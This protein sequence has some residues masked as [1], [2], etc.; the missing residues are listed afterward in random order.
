MTSNVLPFAAQ[1]E[2]LRDEE[3]VRRD[4]ALLDFYRTTERRRQARRLAWVLM[5]CGAVAIASVLMWSR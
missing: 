3:R 5:V 2:H 4:A 1:T